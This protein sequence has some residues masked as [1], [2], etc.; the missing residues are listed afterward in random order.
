MIKHRRTPINV[1]I[2]PGP[3]VWDT[4][5]IPATPVK[6]AI[7]LNTIPKIKYMANDWIW[8]NG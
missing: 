8:F 7:K 6:I 5:N 4:V 2:I 1:T 3:D